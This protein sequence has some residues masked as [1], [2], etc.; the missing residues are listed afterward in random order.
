MTLDEQ[1][2]TTSSVESKFR[3]VLLAQFIHQYYYLQSI[4]NDYRQDVAKSMRMLWR[5]LPARFLDR[6]EMARLVFRY[7][8]ARDFVGSRAFLDDVWAFYEGV[9]GTERDF[10][11]GQPRTLAHLCRC[12]VR[13]VL[14]RNLSLPHG[15]DQLRLPSVLESY[16]KLE[17]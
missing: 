4:D 14:G 6:P 11:S 3:W 1:Q 16:L 2:W 5:N 8:S 13:R 12:R 10:R 7:A 17:H 15:V 9:L